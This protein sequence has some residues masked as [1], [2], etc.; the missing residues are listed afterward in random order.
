LRKIYS[1]KYQLWEEI[2]VETPKPSFTR[3]SIYCLWAE[4]DSMQWKRNTNELISAQILLEEFASPDVN[5]SRI[6][7]LPMS[8]E[9]GHHVV[10]FGL[11]EHLRNWAGRIRELT[12]DSA[13]ECHA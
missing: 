2:L 5:L 8:E 4:V 7:P 1:C 12:I 3:K 11:V 10:A 13:C 6:D 9:T